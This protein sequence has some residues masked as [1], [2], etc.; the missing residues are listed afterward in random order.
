[1]AEPVRIVTCNNAL[2][3]SLPWILQLPRELRDIIY[4]YALVR[5]IIS[6][7]S[8][9]ISVPDAAHS[10][11][12]HFCR[13]LKKTFPFNNPLKHR[14]VWSIPS[15]DIDITF[16]P[17]DMF[18]VPKYVSMTYQLQVYDS[19]DRKIDIALLHTNKQIFREASEVFYGRNTFSFTGDFP[20]P[21]AFAFLCDRSPVSLRLINRIE[22][23]L[24]EDSNMSGTADAHY[25]IAR[26]ATD[27]L[28][29]QFAYNHFTD[30]CTLLASSRMSLRRLCLR[31]NTTSNIWRQDRTLQSAE[32]WLSLEDTDVGRLPSRKPAWIGP[33][34]QVKDLESIGVH[35]GSN[36][37]RPRR[38]ADSVSILR[39][40][41]LKTPSSSDHTVHTDDA[42]VFQLLDFSNASD[43]NENDFFPDESTCG[44]RHDTSLVFREYT[45]YNNG[46]WEKSKC[47]DLENT[48]VIL[49]H[50][51]HLENIL[52][53]EGLYLCYHEAK[54]L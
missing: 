20:L 16:G 4:D 47:Y 29:L 24:T 52:R 27:S 26:R 35:W 19:T 9:A 38:L 22:L 50:R 11:S 36:V 28:V 40:F 43:T 17:Q 34:L 2:S 54:A 18:N 53:S 45:L 42:F 39:K 10:R 3:D 14:R 51:Q 30:L 6:I 32:E 48:A 31:I 12:P 7:Q 33:L 37:L 21:A 13:L 8:A 49:A 23:G 41:M 25:P 5:N 1:M 15:F 44:A 46:T